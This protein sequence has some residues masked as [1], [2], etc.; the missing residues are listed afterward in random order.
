MNKKI[1]ILS[2]TFAFCI[3]AFA[4]GV[5]DNKIKV[6]GQAEV[7]ATPDIM[8]FDITLKVKDSLY[9]Q[10]HNKLVDKYKGIEKSLLSIG[11]PKEDIRSNRVAVSEES[12]YVK[13]K[14]VLDGYSGRMHVSVKREFS[15]KLFGAIMLTLKDSGLDYYCSFDLSNDLKQNI[16]KKVIKEA[17]KDALVKAEIMSNALG[18]KLKGVSEIRYGDFRYNREDVVI[19]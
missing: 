16:K 18:V 3:S 5:S 14:R 15:Y 8:L 4:Q 1:L 2:I 12:K 13:N 11:L 9:N 6:V 19:N 7:F 10:I 17:T